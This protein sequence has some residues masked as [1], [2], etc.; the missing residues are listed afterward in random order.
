MTFWLCVQ[1][2]DGRS[3]YKKSPLIW[4][5]PWPEINLWLFEYQWRDMSEL[6]GHAMVFWWT[7][8]T[9]FASIE[10]PPWWWKYFWKLV[11]TLANIKTERIRRIPSHGDAALSAF[12]IDQGKLLCNP[13]NRHSLGSFNCFTRVRNWIKAVRTWDPFPPRM[14][15]GW[16][17]RPL[18]KIPGGVW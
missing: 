6:T 2:Q 8:I 9:H 11:C 10:H 1:G 18:T 5:N 13:L 17:R 16:N 3:L 14:F 7:E 15:S 12:G 4:S